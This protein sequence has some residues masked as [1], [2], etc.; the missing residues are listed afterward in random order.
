MHSF[1]GRYVSRRNEKVR[2]SVAAIRTAVV[3]PMNE[4]DFQ[5]Q[6]EFS[7]IHTVLRA[8]SV[9]SLRAPIRTLLNPRASE[10]GSCGLCDRR[11]AAKQTVLGPM[12]TCFRQWRKLWT[13]SA[14]STS[15]A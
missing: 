5:L 4:F 6:L 1:I 7:A 12:Q 10:A 9:Q 11:H 14:N 2:N 13:E 15:Y 8:S 3:T